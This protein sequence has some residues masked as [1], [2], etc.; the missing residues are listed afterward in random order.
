MTA[1]VAP[2]QSMFRSMRPRKVRT[3]RAF[4]EADVVLPNGPMRGMRFSC[5][6]CPWTGLL[7]DLYERLPGLRRRFVAGPVQDGKTLIGFVLPI[8]Y[9]LFEVREDVIVGVPDSNLAQGV[10]AEKIEPVIMAS[11][12]ASLM[13][14]KGAGSRGGKVTMIRFRHGPV[15]RFMGAGGRDE[16]R[17]SHTARV[18]CMTEVDKYDTAG[19][20]SRETSPVKQMEARTAAFGD[21]ALIYGECTMSTEDGMVYQEVVELGTDHRVMLPCR[22]CG[23]YQYPERDALVG[24]READSAPSAKRETRYSC[25]GCGAAWDEQDRQ[26]SM[27]SAAIAARGQDVTLEGEVVGELPDTD[28]IGFR[29]NAMASALKTMGGIGKAEWA[30]QRSESEED[31]KYVTQFLWALPWRPDRIDLSGLGRDQVARKV[32]SHGRGERPRDTQAV[33]GFIDVGLYRCWWV[34]WS[35]RGDATGYC[36]DYGG[37]EVWHSGKTRRHA[38]LDTLRQ[39]RDEQ[40]TPAN[41]RL[42]LVD[43]GYESEAVYKFC[44]ESGGQYLPAKGQGTGW[45]QKR[46]NPPKESKGRDW[47]VSPQPDGSPLFVMHADHWKRKVH[48]GFLAAP[49]ERGSLSLYAAAPTQHG[50]F[51]RHITAERQQEEFVAGKGTVLTWVRDRKANHWLD[52]TYGAMAAA[53]S[54][55]IRVVEGEKRKKAAPKREPRDTFRTPDG[56][57]FFVHRR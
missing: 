41:P 21:R 15:L 5:E 28:T 47:Y 1:A 40:M 55:G 54:L 9:H 19:Q 51:G 49:G 27:R 2:V 48:E 45:K 20:A 11:R 30:A 23:V 24:W 50:D 10:W 31:E 8:M 17:S 3:M 26:W 33:T 32:G 18:L 25:T 34:I 4:A 53:D 13:P 12:F 39:I 7:F 37:A 36:Y 38:I 46:W 22:H 44:K 29:W 56:R 35:W 43:S 42:V 57:P 6:F 16:Q 14:A 52:C